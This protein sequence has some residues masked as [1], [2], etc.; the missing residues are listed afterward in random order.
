MSSTRPLIIKDFILIGGY[1]EWNYTLDTN[2]FNTGGAV[3]PSDKPS[4]GSPLDLADASP[5]THQSAN[6]DSPPPLA[7]GNYG[8]RYIIDGR[9]LNASASDQLL[10]IRIGCPDGSGHVSVRSDDGE[11]HKNWQSLF[12]ITD[13]LIP[14]GSTRFTGTVRLTFTPEGGSAQTFDVSVVQGRIQAPQS[15]LDKARNVPKGK[16]VDIR[17]ETVVPTNSTGPLT[18]QFIA[19]KKD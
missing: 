19:G 15:L 7:Y 13:A 8:G 3:L 16:Y 10:D 1:K 12:D 6:V 5:I 14:D 17:L 4:T 9:F 2:P 18:V 11:S